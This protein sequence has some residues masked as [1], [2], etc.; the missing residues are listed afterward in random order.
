M[1]PRGR[2]PKWKEKGAHLIL[3]Y[4]WDKTHLILPTFHPNIFCTDATALKSSLPLYWV[5]I[6]TNKV[7][8]PLF[9][10]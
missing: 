1:Q 2:E 9:L 6:E 3:W 5:E 7:L 8:G 4:T 10:S